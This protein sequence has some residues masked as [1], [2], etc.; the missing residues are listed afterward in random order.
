[1]SKLLTNYKLVQEGR[2]PK[3]EF[4]RQAR[5]EFPGYLSN[6]NS[7]EDSINILRSKGL[8]SEAVYQNVADKFPLEVI[9]KGI[10]IELESI[11]YEDYRNAS[12]GDYK[13][14]KSLV[15]DH[16]VK[17]P[18]YYLPVGKHA[19][20]P[21]Y[22]LGVLGESRRPKKVRT[23]LQERLHKTLHKTVLKEAVTKY[24]DDPNIKEADSKFAAEMQDRTSKAMSLTRPLDDR[25]PSAHS[26]LRSI[27]SEYPEY[28]RPLDTTMKNFKLV[29]E[30]NDRLGKQVLVQKLDYDTFPD[31]HKADSLLTAL[32]DA[33]KT[34]EKTAKTTKDGRSFQRSPQQCL[35]M[36]QKKFPR[37]TRP[38][39]LTMK[40]YGL[41]WE[42][43]PNTGGEVKKL[44]YKGINW[45]KSGAVYKEGKENKESKLLKEAVKKLVVKVLS[46]NKEKK[47]LSE[48]AT[49]NLAQLS[50]QN[51][52]IQGLPAILN[53]LENVVTEI[54]SF[55]LKETTKIQGIFDSIGNIKNDDGMPIGYQFAQPILD[56]FSKDLQPVL[57]K[58]DFVGSINLPAAPQMTAEPNL[59]DPNN[60]EAPEEKQTVFTPKPAAAPALDDKQ[61]EPLAENKVSKRRYTV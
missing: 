1:M 40:N 43:V 2:M 41:T 47:I 39:K 18:L 32:L 22:A 38:L 30:W 36:V 46:E 33:S 23:N 20:D 57:E 37:F 15:I 51:A 52:T 26:I 13:K 17:D 8:L 50:D 12:V 6:Q 48:A 60:P 56:S 7:Y 3:G 24:E 31:A 21:K 35:E 11:G 45:R 61:L 42:D 28:S 34:N 55:A 59:E 54:E 58:M 27:Q 29:W 49:A 10:K 9:E 19:E 14:A 4:L 44:V 25:I 16:L 5:Q 53:N